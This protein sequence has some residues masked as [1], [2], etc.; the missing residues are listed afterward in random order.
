GRKEVVAP[1]RSLWREGFN[2]TNLFSQ[3]VNYDPPEEPH[4]IIR[5]GDRD[6]VAFDLGV[7]VEVVCAFAQV[8]HHRNGFPPIDHASLDVDGIV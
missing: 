1:R 7:K 8:V 2:S 3:V 5:N 6:R 4:S